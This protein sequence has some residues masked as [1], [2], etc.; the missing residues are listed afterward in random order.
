[1]RISDWS[2]YVCSSDLTDRAVAD[3]G[4]DLGQEIAADDHRL[5]FRVVDV[6]G[7]DRAAA[8]DLVADEFGRDG[9]LDAGAEGLPRVLLAQHLVAHRFEALVL[10]DRD[11]LHLRRDDAATRVVHLADVGAGLC[12][13]WQPDR[14]STRLNSSP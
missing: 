10:A 4:V 7:Q 2:S 8:G 5:A 13:A 12:N 9:L 3:V 6:V 1:M 14:K 11:V